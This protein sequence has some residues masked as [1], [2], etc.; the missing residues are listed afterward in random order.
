M[1]CLPEAW[2]EESQTTR[3]TPTSELLSHHKCS[4]FVRGSS[5]LHHRCDRKLTQTLTQ[6]QCL[7]RGFQDMFMLTSFLHC[8]KSPPLQQ[9][10][11]I[12]YHVVTQKA[13]LHMYRTR[14]AVCLF[15][16]PVNCILLWKPKL[17]HSSPRNMVAIL[18]SFLEINYTPVLKWHFIS[19]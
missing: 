8:G 14:I 11:K 3:S 9:A 15:D 1:L 4:L 13:H 19:S 6:G 10:R 17:I 12:L 5:R 2:K 18:Q 16:H 7:W